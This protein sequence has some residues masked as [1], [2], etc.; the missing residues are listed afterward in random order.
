MSTSVAISIGQAN[1]IFIFAPFLLISIKLTPIIAGHVN[2]DKNANKYPMNNAK[3]GKH[4]MINGHPK[5]LNKVIIIIAHQSR[6]SRLQTMSPTPH[7]TNTNQTLTP[8]N[9]NT[10]HLKTY[11]LL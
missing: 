2:K 9:H 4:I 7:T 10:Y 11:P 3:L 6:T 8:N 1:L 5:Q